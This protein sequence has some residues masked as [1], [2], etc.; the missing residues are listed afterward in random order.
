VLTS[1]NFIAARLKSASALTRDGIEREFKRLEEIAAQGLS[2]T[3]V[4]GAICRTARWP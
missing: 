4:M 3:S 2:E 1:Y